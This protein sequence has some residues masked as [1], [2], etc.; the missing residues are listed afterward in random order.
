MPPLRRTAVGT[1]LP[2]LPRKQR[3]FSDL[4]SSAGL[5]RTRERIPVFPQ[6]SLL[7]LPFLGGCGVPVG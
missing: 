1:R 4:C 3:G 6:G 2:L 7:S 5:Q